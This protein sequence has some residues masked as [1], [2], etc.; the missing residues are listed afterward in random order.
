MKKQF[1]YSML[2]AAAMMASCSSDR[3]IAPINGVEDGGDGY[4][5]FNISMPQFGNV[6]RA[7]DD[8]SDGDPVPAEYKVFNAHLVLFSGG[9]ESTAKFCGAYKMDISNFDEIGSATDQCTSEGKVTQK[10]S[11]PT[12]GSTDKLYAY[13]IINHNGI[14][15][16]PSATSV[17]IKTT[18]GTDDVTMTV[19]NTVT[20]PV[21]SKYVLSTY[22]DREVGGLLMT[23]CPLNGVKGGTEAAVDKLYTLAT[24]D[25]TKIYPTASAAEADPAGEVF[26]ERAAAKVTVSVSAGITGTL[27]DDASI[28]Y[29]KAN[30]MWVLNNENQAYYNTR[31]MKSDWL[32][33]AANQTTYKE[34]TVPT[35][36]LYRFV[37]KDAIHS[38]E[39]RTYWGEDVNYN[40]DEWATANKFSFKANP[41]AIDKEMGT[42]VYTFE[43]TFD[44]DHQNSYNT[45][46]VA[47]AVKFNEGK[48]FY[49]AST[50]GANKI[51]QLPAAS[52]GEKVQDYIMKYLKSN[53][54]EFKAWYD[55]DG[56]N[57]I[58]VTMSDGTDGRSTVA[59]L[60]AESS[61]EAFDV[62][63]GTFTSTSLIADINAAI[64]F[65]YYKNGMAYYHSRIKH[66]GAVNPETPWDATNHSSNT[67]AGVY[68]TFG[69]SSLTDQEAEANYLGRYGVL[70]NNWYQVEVA[71]IK[72]IGTPLPGNPS[73][74]TPTD[75]ED[76]WT[77]D[78]PDDEVENYISVKIHVTPWALRKQ[79]V[80]L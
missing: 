29:D 16:N 6:T 7:N 58:T 20:F 33:L 12:L 13:V 25:A 62:L 41:T 35:T 53:N 65:N 27:E 47:F 22:G 48:T 5:A 54:T 24:L 69:T 77:P 39:F 11:K 30:I 56:S 61:A 38:A 2:A 45:T 42:S 17:D 18:D 64:T 46:Q 50:Y 37:S 51:L 55:H 80:T 67:I 23:N 14:I 32:S 49:T 78:T 68:K 66:F 79:S 19:D 15:T 28:T 9:S 31:Q 3:E 76:P 71:G 34:A 21:F 4:V 36:T 72:Q 8:F 52:S 10:I 26:V 75:P 60:T 57:R 43:N 73:K 44:V 63:G 70:R 59:T 1:F 40:I 74:D